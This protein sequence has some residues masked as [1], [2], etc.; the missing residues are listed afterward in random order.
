MGAG[1]IDAIAYAEATISVAVADGRRGGAVRHVDVF[2]NCGSHR[3]V[4]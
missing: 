2:A 1:H 3:Q 4:G